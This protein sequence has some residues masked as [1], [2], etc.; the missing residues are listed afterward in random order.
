MTRTEALIAIRQ[1]EKLIA[2]FGGPNEQYCL[3]FIRI[4][5]DLR[6]GPLKD[7]SF[8]E[9]LS[10]LEGWA[11]EGFSRILCAQYSTRLN[12]IRVWAWGDA[13]AARTLIGEHWP[14]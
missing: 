4:I 13:N 2:C 11:V 5:A 8:R 1:I 10:N 14:S 9:T 12:Q 7:S 6:S 3:E